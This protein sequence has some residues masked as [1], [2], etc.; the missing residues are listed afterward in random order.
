MACR[1]P[2]GWRHLGPVRVRCQERVRD[3]QSAVGEAFNWDGNS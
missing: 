1:S 2:D 3:V